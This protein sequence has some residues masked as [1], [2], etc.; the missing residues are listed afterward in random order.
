MAAIIPILKSHIQPKYFARGLQRLIIILLVVAP[1]FSN[2]EILKL[3]ES[4][5]APQYTLNLPLVQNNEPSNTTRSLNDYQGKV[6]LL[7]FW[8]SWCGPCRHSFPWMNDLKIKH[9]HKDF[10][11]VAVNVDTQTAFAHR[12]LTKVPAEFDVLLDTNAKLQEAFDVLGMPTSF[13]LD[14][15][16]RVRASHVGFNTGKINIYEA[17]ILELLS[18]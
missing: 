12:F 7:D 10:A 5:L 11:I 14:K 13:L 2:A 6:V 3:T 18:E 15:E 4:P 9:A 16:G 17:D 8:A 1:L